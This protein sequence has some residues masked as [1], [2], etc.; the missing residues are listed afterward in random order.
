[1]A[2]LLGLLGRADL[3]DEQVTVCRDLLERVG[4][5]EATEQMISATAG[6]ALEALEATPGLTDEGRAALTELVAISTA[7]A[8]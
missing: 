8:T 3:T 4:A 6:A 2:T 5:V 1:M 7:R